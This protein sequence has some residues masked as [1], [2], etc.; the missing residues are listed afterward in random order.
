MTTTNGF[1]S[2]LLKTPIDG[3][4][5]IRVHIDREYREIVE[6]DPDAPP[7]R[8][9]TF[10]LLRRSDSAAFLGQGPTFKAAARAAY[11]TTTTTEEN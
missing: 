4:A 8:Q 1:A 9:W 11:A 10:L 5:S 7:E 6:R 2:P 3:N